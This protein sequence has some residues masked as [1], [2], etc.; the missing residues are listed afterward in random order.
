MA[1]TKDPKER[2]RKRCVTL[3]KKIA[4]L[5]AKEICEHCG[6]RKQD[7]WQMHGSHIYPEGVY[8]SMSADVDN[9]ICLCAI[10]HVGG[11]WKNSKN[12]SWHEDPVYFVDWFKKKYPKRAKRLKQQ[13]RT[14]VVCDMQY[15][16]DKL[17]ELKVIHSPSEKARYNKDMGKT[18]KEYLSVEL[19]KK[20][21]KRTRFLR[22]LNNVEKEIEEL[23]EELKK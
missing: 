7:G 20:H 9:I 19:R 17:E 10:C 5:K 14:I 18:I 11:F 23:E 22:E 16:E 12:P 21:S 4:R 1:K 6:K 13:T 2:L 3:A 8:K 15:W